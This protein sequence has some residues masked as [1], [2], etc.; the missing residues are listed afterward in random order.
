MTQNA[1][2]LI[3]DDDAVARELIETHLRPEG[4]RLALAASGREALEKAGRLKPDLVILDVMMPHM[5]GFEVCRRLR[6]HPRLGEV[7]V[8]MLTALDDRT[9]KIKGIQAGAD[10]FL[11]KPYDSTELKARVR[12][13]TRLDRY[14]RLVDERTKFE[15]VVN[16]SDDGYLILAA[17][18]DE[19]VWANPKART[20]LRLAASGKV[21]DPFLVLATVRYRCEPQHLWNHWPDPKATPLFMLQP[22]SPSANA[23]WLRVDLL[24]LPSSSD[25]RLVRLRDQTSRMALGRNLSK[26]S[27][28]VSE[29]L[30]TPL[31]MT[32]GSLDMMV[33]DDDR[34]SAD[35]LERVARLAQR[36]GQR[37]E[38]QIKEILALLDQPDRVQWDAGV[39]TEQIE[40]LV[41]DLA[42]AMRLSPV[43]V[44][45]DA[46]VAGRL[47]LSPVAFEVI[48]REMFDN[49]RQFHP[50]SSPTLRLRLAPGDD[51]GRKKVR[52]ELRNDDSTASADQLHRFWIPYYQNEDDA[53]VDAEGVGFGVSMVGTLVWG[54]GG[55]CQISDLREGGGVLVEIVLPLLEGRSTF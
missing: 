21:E 9:S 35:D 19:V 8:I 55:T 42:T 14:R 15:W 13:V 4:Y 48:L 50:T 53:S 20:L 41:A 51:T 29:K 37:L 30:S 32:L 43:A 26:F 54:L 2:I 46:G 40:S 3:V 34:L 28:L 47:P 17:E 23:L 5:D 24:E 11:S 10:D 6:A 33:S 44:S 36:S 49:A 39:D 52:L 22:E 18:T 7:P 31:K 45:Q 27:S 1:T 12:T 25:A 16:Q 38:Q